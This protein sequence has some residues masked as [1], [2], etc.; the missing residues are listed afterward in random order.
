MA[1][2]ITMEWNPW[3]S[4]EQSL[5]NKKTYFHIINTVVIICSKAHNLNHTFLQFSDYCIDST[6]QN[7]VLRNV[8]SHRR[9]VAGIFCKYSLLIDSTLSV[10]CPT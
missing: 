6:V 1:S 3:N 2:G 8:S 5:P 4:R 9:T 10:K 7:D